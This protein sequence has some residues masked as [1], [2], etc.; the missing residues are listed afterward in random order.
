MIM[1]KE[2]AAAQDTL[3]QTSAPEPRSTS[4]ARLL[5]IDNLRVLLIIL[6]IV[7]HM[8]I[9]YGAP[10]GE[11]YYRE[12]GQVGAAFE[13]IT[14]LLLGIGSSFLL[15][16]FYMIA[17]YFTPPAYNHKGTAKFILER[18]IRLGIPLILYAVV[19]NPIVT[20]WAAKPGGYDGTFLQYVPGHL[21]DLINASIGPLWF[22]E[23]LLIFS[24][25]YALGRLIFKG[26]SPVLDDQPVR[27]VPGN[28]SV[29]LFAFGLGLVTFL[30]RVWAPFGWWWEPIHQEPGHFPQYIAFFAVGIS[31]YRNNWFD[32]ISS[33]QARGWGWAALGLIPVL[34]ALSIW[35]GALRGE[36]NPDIAG[37]FNWLS[38][39]YSMWEALIGVA[40]VIAGLVW[41]RD[42]LNH[43]GRLVQKM[44]SAA[45][46]VYILHPLVI[47]P[48][49]LSLRSISLNL[50]LKFLLFAPLAVVICFT[51][52]Y[53]ARLLP[54]IK[55][56][57]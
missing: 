26:K 7:G 29:I 13:I 21:P 11:W 45:Y 48:L 39:A 12:E 25:L 28:R 16:L 6:V 30:V 15:G 38:L 34:A 14:I 35:A 24:L 31:A 46:A 5:Y 44:S 49:A 36:F 2:P 9:T 33:R 4:K 42:R 22:I 53:L 50:D 3:P 55:R 23:A 20:Y 8:A 17:G 41:F 27:S 37:G 51:I 40:L 43:Q 18:L 47:V 57:L 52:G 1:S 56:I 32:L 10:L 54:L 19:I